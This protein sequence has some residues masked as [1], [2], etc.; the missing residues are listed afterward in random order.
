AQA[1]ATPVIIDAEIRDG[2]FREA[3]RAK[4]IPMLL[5]EGGEALRFEEP[6]I[7]SGVRGIVNVMRHLGMLPAR[8]KPAKLPTQILSTQWLRASSSGILRKPRALGTVVRQDEI[9]GTISDPFG[10]D[11]IA[12]TA[13]YDSLIIG[14]LNLPMVNE[15]EAVFHLA[16]F[17]DHRDMSTAV[18]AVRNTMEDIP[19]P[20][21]YQPSAD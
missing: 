4:G 7:Q 20:R 9:V 8:G 12:L 5:Y 19:E 16:R 13:P 11:E 10:D 15:G 6:A 17:D 3:A 1:F 14:R 18:A 2:S 21:D